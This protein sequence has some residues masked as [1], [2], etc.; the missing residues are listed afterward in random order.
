MFLCLQLNFWNR[1]Q[2][3]PDTE[4]KQSEKLINVINNHYCMNE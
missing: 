2:Y 4:D 1:L 3:P